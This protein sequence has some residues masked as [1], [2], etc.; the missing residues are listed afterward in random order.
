MSRAQRIGIISDTHGQLDDRVL[1]I[2]AGV[3]RIVHAGDVG[4]VRLLV[5]H[6]KGTLM[7]DH[8]LAREGIAVVVTGHTHRAQITTEGGVLFV[9]P[10]TA[11]QSRAFGR[12]ASVA[13]LDIHGPEVDARIIPL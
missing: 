7:R 9:D 1:E 2:F 8:D 11:N 3:N 10:G 13:L 6:V 5:G 4:G 12:R